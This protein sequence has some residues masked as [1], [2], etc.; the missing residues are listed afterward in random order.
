MARA[1]KVAP[2][3]P[4]PSTTCAFAAYDP[5]AVHCTHLYWI[6]GGVEGAVEGERE[7][8][9]QSSKPTKYRSN[10]SSLC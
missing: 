2:C 4:T 1:R 3:P 5:V 6:G 8:V 7:A 9:K 10:K